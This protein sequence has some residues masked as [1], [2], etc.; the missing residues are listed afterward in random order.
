[1]AHPEE[2]Q[3][4]L[5]APAVSPSSASTRGDL[6]I[7]LWIFAGTLAGCLALYAALTVPASWFPG[8]ATKS[9]GA[10][11]FAVVRGSGGLG[12]GEI[13]ITA[14]DSSGLALLSANADFRAADYPVVAWSGAAFPE[15]ADVRFLWRT[16]Y[17]PA[18]LNS[19]PVNVVA[20]R[21]T[22]VVMAGKADWAGRITGV[23]LAVR[24]PIGEP[25]RVQSM[26]ARAGGFLAQIGD[27]FREWLAFEPWSGSSINTITGGADVQEL[28]LP[29]FM[30][31]ALA[32]AA[33]LWL[34]VAWRAHRTRALP[35]VLAL[36]FVAGWLLLDAQWSFNLARQVAQ[37]RAQY[38]GKDWHERHLA[39]EDAPL[40]SF[41]E[42]AR[43]KLPATPARVFIVADAAY[44]RGRAAYHLYP[45]NVY[46]DPR[47]NTLPAT[48][49]L[50]PGDYVLVYQRRGV[51]YNAEERKLRFEGSEPVPAEALLV[52]GG[53]A[54]FRI[55]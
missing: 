47:N 37:T 8:A 55:L 50:H 36:L 1:M 43:E 35:V 5:S 25:L 7:A 48:S 27:R 15:G 31:V 41:I 54:L 18:K 22:P 10:R 42:K 23:A 4:P 45:H 14:P 52:E 12:R 33:A 16:D 38:G 17:S 26:D 20:G 3:R 24:G 28:P 13:V 51:Q 40:F 6:R 11:D 53:A 34:A 44:F 29:T 46:Y 19:V 49:S 32:L 9:F 39:A 30:V 21:L 2:P